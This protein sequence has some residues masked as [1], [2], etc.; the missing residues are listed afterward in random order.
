MWTF[1]NTLRPCWNSEHLWRIYQYANILS[2]VRWYRPSTYMC[3]NLSY[4]VLL[5][6]DVSIN[7]IRSELHRGTWLIIFPSTVCLNYGRTLIFI[8]WKYQWI[9]FKHTVY[10][11]IKS[12]VIQFLACL[13]FK[14]YLKIKNLF[15]VV[16]HN[17]VLEC[18]QN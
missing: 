3:Q 11:D 4:C 5:S 18:I 12:L 7:S 10:L 14:I 8:G 17:V 6:I 16:K 15:T 2:W 1:S 13:C 9:N